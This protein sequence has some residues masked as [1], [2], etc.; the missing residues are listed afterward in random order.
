MELTL[1]SEGFPCARATESFVVSGNGFPI[2]DLSY[3]LEPSGDTV[4]V[5]LDASASYD[6]DPGDQISFEWY[7]DGEKVPSTP[8]AWVG[9][10]GMSTS[11]SDWGTHN[12]KVAV[13]DGEDTS[14]ASVTVD[15]SM[16]VADF[17][18]TPPSGT[19]PLAVSFDASAS[20]DPYFTE[21]LSYMWDFG[22]GYKSWAPPVGQHDYY[23][24]TTHT[25]DNPGTYTAT[26]F[27]TNRAGVT[28]STSRQITVGATA[29]VPTILESED[30][31][32]MLEM[33]V[34]SP[35][36]DTAPAPLQ[37]T[38][39]EP[40]EVPNNEESQDAGDGGESTLVPPTAPLEP[41][42]SLIYLPWAP[43][44]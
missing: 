2:S 33:T 24:K 14:F 17:T 16:P 7:L 34:P 20:S 8:G 30:D 44:G 22:D 36:E 31:E 13:S 18:A 28:V 12:W 23:E 35:L 40:L 37:M 9:G 42:E 4:Q 39:P 6:P 10:S 27:V 19:A 41:P 43:I 26:V 38:V 3:Q 32:D 5:T 29:T 21:P 11:I 25:Y 1:F 15:V